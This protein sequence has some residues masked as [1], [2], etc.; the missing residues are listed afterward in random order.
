[1]V[2]DLFNALTPGLFV[3]NKNNKNWGLGQIQSSIRNIITVNFEN[4]GKKV[5][6]ANEINLEIVKSD[7]SIRSI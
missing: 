4:V 5:I 1:M 3:I 6:N 2:S 7:V